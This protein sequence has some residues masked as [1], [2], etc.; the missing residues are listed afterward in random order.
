MLIQSTCSRCL[1][2]P[3]MPGVRAPLDA[4]T[5]RSL[6]FR[7]SMPMSWFG[8]ILPM[9]PYGRPTYTTVFGCRRLTF[10][11]AS[12]AFR[13]LSRVGE[14]D[15]SALRCG[16]TGSCSSTFQY[17]SL[18]NHLGVT[19]SPQSPLPAGYVTLPVDGRSPPLGLMPP[20]SRG[21]QVFTSSFLFAFQSYASPDGA[22]RTVGDVRDPRLVRNLGKKASTNLGA[23][24]S[25]PRCPSPCKVHEQLFPG[26]GAGR[27]E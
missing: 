9:T 17:F 22:R 16:L 11:A 8:C 2:I 18:E 4:R 14:G 24:H 12:S 19:A 1:S 3:S 27:Q 15:L 26:G 7:K 13:L 5:I 10:P 23:V 20:R 6:A 25:Q 21:R